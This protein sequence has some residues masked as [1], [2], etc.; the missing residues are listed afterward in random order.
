VG[1]SHSQKYTVAEMFLLRFLLFLCFPTTCIVANPEVISV[2]IISNNR[3]KPLKRLCESLLLTKNPKNRKVD[4]IFNLEASSSNEIVN[5]VYGFYWP[6]GEKTVR[7]RMV[8][9]GLIPAVLESWFPAHS[10]DYGVFLED[11]IEVS[12]LW[13]IWIDMVL[14]GL[15]DGVFE[16]LNDR[17]M[18]ISLYSPRITETVFPKP[19]FDS[20][21]ITSLISGD[22]QYPYLMQ[23]PCSWGALFFPTHWREFMSYSSLRRASNSTDHRVVIPG[24]RTNGWKQSW[25]R[26]MFEIMYLRGFFMIY[27]NFADQQSLSTNHMEVGEHITEKKA[28]L[29]TDFTVPL[30]L[31]DMVLSSVRLDA[32]VKLAVLDLFGKPLL[33]PPG[34]LKNI[35]LQKQKKN[36]KKLENG[37]LERDHKTR[38]SPG[39]NG[40]KAPVT[41]RKRGRQGA[42]A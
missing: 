8:Q 42:T 15:K 29:Q 28:Q 39:K 35:L 23:T 13:L 26:F 34:P 10:L 4:L 38:E 22:P 11:D 20:T 16:P 1:I 18:G 24:S 14:E 36:H 32:A 7:I 3:T 12:P 33:S 27:P 25:K 30:L 31:D 9:G 41:Q 5:Y 6:F 19:K 17:I 37:N 21:Q 40:D 2:A